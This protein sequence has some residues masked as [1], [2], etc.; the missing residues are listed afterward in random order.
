MST[1]PPTSAELHA[2]P[3]PPLG[4]T[5]RAILMAIEREAH[6]AVY[7]GSPVSDSV[8][9]PLDKVVEILRRSSE[10][11]KEDQR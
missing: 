2:P 4:P 11:T 8:L 9:V 5:E 3:P 7:Y 10:L 6:P 1:T